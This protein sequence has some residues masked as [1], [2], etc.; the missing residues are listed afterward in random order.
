MMEAYQDAKREKRNERKNE[1]MIEIE[2]QLTYVKV[3]SEDSSCNI[4]QYQ[5]DASRPESSSMSPIP[6]PDARST[7]PP[8]PPPPV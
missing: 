8:W 3:N 2:S 5:G 6:F 4:M 7:V 1:K